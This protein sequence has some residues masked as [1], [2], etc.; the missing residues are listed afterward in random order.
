M[1]HQLGLLWKKLR[2]VTGI[3]PLVTCVLT[4]LPLLYSS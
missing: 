4:Y 2:F 1:A 3:L